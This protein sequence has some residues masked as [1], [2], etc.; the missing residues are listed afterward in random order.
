MYRMSDLNKVPNGNIPRHLF[1]QDYKYHFEYFVDYACIF[2]INGSSHIIITTIFHKP[3][4][5]NNGA[6]YM[7]LPT[8][9]YLQY[10]R[11]FEQIFLTVSQKTFPCITSNLR[12][13]GCL[14]RTRCLEPQVLGK[15]GGQSADGAGSLGVRGQGILFV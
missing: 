2:K 5:T 13:Q 11:T 4:N 14:N 10:C 6:Y 3:I 1:Q 9:I 8:I 7:Y 15:L 12:S